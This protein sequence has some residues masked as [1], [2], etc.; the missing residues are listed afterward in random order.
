MN[1]EPIEQLL[2][3]V[4]APEYQSDEHRRRL[5]S[6]VLAQVEAGKTG[7]G[8]RGGWKAFALVLGLLCAG[9]A[10]TE[11]AIQ[12]HR[13]YFEGRDA[14]GRYHF[15]EEPQGVYKQAYVD[16]NG[17]TQYVGAAGASLITM[18]S[19]DELDA[20]AIEQKRKDL[21]EIAILRQKNARELLS[22]TDTAVNGRPGVRAYCFRYVLADGR[23]ETMGEGG[24]D[25]APVSPEQME[26]EHQEI[27][28]LRQEG[29]R[30]VR[31]VID[32][33]LEGQ[34]RRTLICSYLLSDGREVSVGESDSELRPPSKGLTPEQQQEL[35]RLARLKQGQFLGATEA[36]MFGKVFT[37]QRYSYTLPDGTVVAYSEGEP[38][39]AKRNLTEAD[40][41]ELRDLR[42]AKAGEILGTYEEEV[43]GKVF[44]FT[45][46]RYVLS[47]GTEVVQSDGEPVS[48]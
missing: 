2:K 7:P 18:A 29:R 20:A 11:V 37:F 13:Y 41:K 25:R 28:Q 5:R 35:L 9:A 14:E 47:D 39:E 19:S 31:K 30:D 8:L 12:V 48:K 36:Q 34:I 26:R 21:E 22:V 15:S 27:A 42:Q 32:T 3:G 40:W 4:V 6:E 24:H 46:S 43:R 17:V 33:D 44:K 23:T 45:T 16:A 10:A 1:N 38:Q